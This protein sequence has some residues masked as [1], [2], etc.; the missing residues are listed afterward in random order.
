PHGIL[1]NF[2]PDYLHVPEDIL[3]TVMRTH[4]R[5][6]PVRAADG[7]LLPHFITFANGACDET[8]V[9]SGNENVLRARYEDAAF[10]YRT[11]LDV[12]LETFRENIA[13][14]T[15]ENRLGSMSE[16][17]DRIRDVA[18]A[19]A[20]ELDRAGYGLGGSEVATLARAGEL[21]KFDLATGMVVEL[22]SLA[23]VMAKEY[24]LKAG[25]TPEVAEA[26]FE[27]ELPRHTGDAL[28]ASTPGALLALAD[29]FD[30]L[31]AMFAIGV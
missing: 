28:P 10:F 5:Y 12:P 29:R 9:R 4:Q 24:A 11:D 31:T 23:G 13:G 27:L 21:A 22:S 18:A 8:A 6:L 7:S 16:R 14:L 20:G 3:T 17:A 30:L 19:L 25:E 2:D 1:G 26:L 15:F